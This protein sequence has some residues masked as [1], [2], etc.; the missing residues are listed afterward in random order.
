MSGSEQDTH[1]ALAFAMDDMVKHH[2]ETANVVT[3]HARD[4]DATLPIFLLAY[5]AS[6]HDTM[7]MT[8][9]SVVFER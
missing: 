1:H 6:T 2:I 9:A 8:L 7:N 5:R 3:L 4:W